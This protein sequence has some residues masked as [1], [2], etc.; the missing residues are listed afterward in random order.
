METAATGQ[1]D[2]TVLK[3]LVAPDDR[4]EPKLS[5]IEPGQHLCHRTRSDTKPAG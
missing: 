5:L 3:V 2:A 1:R 4:V